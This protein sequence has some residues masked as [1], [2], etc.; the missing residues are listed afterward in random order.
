MKRFYDSERLQKMT[1]WKRFHREM[2][3]RKQGLQ[4]FCQ[5]K[6]LKQARILSIVMLIS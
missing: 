3:K 4:A 2:R 5:T 1:G 6:E